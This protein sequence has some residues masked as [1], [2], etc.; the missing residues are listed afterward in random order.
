MC[1]GS[2]VVAAFA[3]RQRVSNTIAN[4]NHVYVLII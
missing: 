1:F 2:E 4:E 3:L